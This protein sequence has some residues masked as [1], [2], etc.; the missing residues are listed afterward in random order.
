MFNTGLQMISTTA[1]KN[2]DDYYFFI[3]DR[4]TLSDF[5][6]EKDIKL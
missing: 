3:V 1:C 6:A 2:Y 4:L 5:N